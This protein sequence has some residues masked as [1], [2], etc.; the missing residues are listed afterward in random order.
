MLRRR[1]GESRFSEL[2]ESRLG[3]RFGESRRRFGERRIC[4]DD[5]GDNTSLTNSNVCTEEILNFI[6]KIFDELILIKQKLNQVSAPNEISDEDAGVAD[7]SGDSEVFDQDDLEPLDTSLQ[8]SKRFSMKT[9][10]HLL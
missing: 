2:N 6:D 8:E 5:F 1:F 9:P 7:Y 4:E 10:K 3:R